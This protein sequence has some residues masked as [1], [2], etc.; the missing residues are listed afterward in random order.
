MKIKE[1]NSTLSCIIK[2]LRFFSS[3]INKKII[4]GLFLVGFLEGC[5][6]PT[7]MLAPAYTLSTSGNLLQA[8][9]SY[10][11]NEMISAQTGKTTFE[12]I[13]DLEL[14]Q[15]KKNI[16]KKTLKSKDFSLMVKNRIEKTRKILKLSN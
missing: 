6:S 13:K 8:G 5:S 10:G 9:F 12:N 15:N 16:K 4:F 11:T 14:F 1:L 7:A 2:S 3:M